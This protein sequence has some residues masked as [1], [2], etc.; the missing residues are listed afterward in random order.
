MTHS[1][2]DTL[3]DASEAFRLDGHVV[4][5]TGGYGVLGSAMSRGL[6]DAG[7]SV[8]LLGR[9]RDKAA[10]AAHALDPDGERAFGVAADVLD[11]GGLA[12]ARDAVLDRFGRIDALVNAAGGNVSGATLAPGAS[13]FGLDADA[14]RSVVDLNLHGTILPTQAF[15]PALADAAAGSVVNVS[16]MA[17]SRVISRVAGYSAAKAAVDQYT[18]WM[19][20]E[21]AKQT[22]GRVRVNAVAPGFFVAEQ[23]RSLL[24]DADGGLTE[25]GRDIVAHTPSGRFGE[26]DEV[27]GAVVFLCSSAARFVTGVVLPVDG[28]FSAYGGF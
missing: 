21:L 8:V 14:W 7:A 16:S 11:E 5:V 1:D 12:D 2:T 19:A 13:P 27:A 28:G 26:P 15:G 22:E 25:R 3:P 20:V 24:I 18:R 6:M 9:S 17:A 23:N 4:V 10:A